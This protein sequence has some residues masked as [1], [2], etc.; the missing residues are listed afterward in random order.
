MF[1]ILTGR[2]DELQLIDLAVLVGRLRV[3]L[4]GALVECGPTALAPTLIDSCRFGWSPG[5]LSSL[6]DVRVFE[7][8][9]FD[10]LGDD[11]H[12][13]RGGVVCAAASGLVGFPLPLPV[14]AI[15]RVP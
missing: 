13:H 5:S 12:L 9:V 2:V 14:L 10:V 4:D 6:L 1:S 15:E 11:L 8:Q 7:R 3:E